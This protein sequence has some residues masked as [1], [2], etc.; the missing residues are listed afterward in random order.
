MNSIFSLH[1]YCS[2]ESRKT[3][4]NEPAPTIKT[5][6]NNTSQQQGPKIDN[7]VTPSIS[8]K[9]PPLMPKPVNIQ[10]QTVEDGS[11]KL[12]NSPSKPPLPPKPHSLRHS[13]K[14]KETLSERENELLSVVN[15]D[16]VTDQEGLQLQ[17]LPVEPSSTK[18]N[19]TVKLES[20]IKPPPP[21][22]PHK[23]FE[24]K[25]KKGSRSFSST[26]F[27]SPTKESKRN[28][29]WTRKRRSL[30]DLRGVP[31][32]VMRERAALSAKHGSTTIEELE[33]G[34]SGEYCHLSA[35]LD[36]TLFS[37]SFSIY[38]AFCFFF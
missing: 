11:G 9:K 30:N 25:L 17:S 4:I 36:L 27:S 3:P 38:H 28:S 23:F 15:Y 34:S 37:Q 1:Y 33:G 24:K 12:P 19:G 29:T 35:L 13:S 22:A 26:D 21:S 31:V 5:P 14:T 2:M 32:E 20:S 6:P 7:V 10:R 16:F 18:N 8:P